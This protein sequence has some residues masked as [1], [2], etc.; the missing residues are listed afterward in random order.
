MSALGTL[1]LL[2]LAAAGV[3]R[4]ALRRAPLAVW[5]APVLLVVSVAVTV[6]AVRYRAPAEPFLV[7]AAAFALSRSD[8]M[9]RVALGRPVA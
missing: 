8:R 4:G 9:D 2:L 3:A 7:L 1:V 5:L 6:S